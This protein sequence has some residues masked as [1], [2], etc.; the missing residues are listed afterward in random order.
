MAQIE[1][2]FGLPPSGRF[3]DSRRHLSPVAGGIFTDSGS[4]RHI[5]LS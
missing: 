4:S 2:E 1:S 3:P 5:L